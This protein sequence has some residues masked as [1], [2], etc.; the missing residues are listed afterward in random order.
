MGLVIFQF[1]VYRGLRDPS[2]ELLTVTI[3]PRASLLQCLDFPTDIIILI[4][5]II[6]IIIIIMVVS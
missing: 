4:I 2:F 3:G 5:I 1:W 6:I